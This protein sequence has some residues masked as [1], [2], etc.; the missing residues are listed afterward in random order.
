MNRKRKTPLGMEEVPVKQMRKSDRSWQ[1]ARRHLCR[2]V[3]GAL[4]V[5]VFAVFRP[6][7]FLPGPNESFLDV[8]K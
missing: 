2:L 3:E 7:V 1:L 8:D 6:M 5:V 4:I